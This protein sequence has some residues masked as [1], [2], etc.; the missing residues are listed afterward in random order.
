MKKRILLAA[1]ALALS[2]SLPALAAE[3]PAI[4]VQLDGQNLTFTD[5]VPQVKDQR[6]FLPFRAVFEAMGA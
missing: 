5:A 1:A 2:L 3:E 4:Q 6:T